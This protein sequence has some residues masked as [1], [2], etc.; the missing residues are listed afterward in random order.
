M[1]LQRGT[2]GKLE[3]YVNVDR[4]IAVSMS[5]SGGAVYD[6]CCFGVDA[7]GKLSDDR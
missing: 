2:R 7:D 1:I 5:V 3:Q 4:E 6:Y